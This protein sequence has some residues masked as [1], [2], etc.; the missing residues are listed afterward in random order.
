MLMGRLDVIACDPTVRRLLE[1]RAITNE[2]TTRQYLCAIDSFSRFKNMAP[3]RLVDHLKNL[4]IEEATEEVIDWIRYA[5]RRYSAKSTRNWLICL[6]LWLRENG[7]RVDHDEIKRAFR[8]YIGRV[9][10]LL[11]RDIITRDEL[12]KILQHCDIRSR[13]LFTFAASSGLRV[14]D[15]IIHLRLRDIKDDLWDKNL[16]CYLVE[17]PE[18]YTKDGVAHVTFISAECAQYLRTYL[19]QRENKGEN[20]TSDSLLFVARGRKPM[21][22]SL[23]TYLWA[24]ACKRAGVDRR[25]VKAKGFQYIRGAGLRPAVR[26][27]IRVHSLRKY[28][29]TACSTMGVDRMVSE[30]FLG[31]SLSAFGIESVYDFCIANLDYLRTQYQLVLPLVTFLVEPPSVKVVANHKARRE[32]EVLKAE[33]RRLEETVKILT[34]GLLAAHGLTQLSKMEKEKLKQLAEVQEALGSLQNRGDA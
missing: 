24:E 25:P 3:S 13:A 7:V 22:V 19:K 32:I 12:I 29:K 9:K 6:R 5:K 10:R 20:I 30:A 1:R 31:H 16:P 27:N 2:A 26:Y 15:T 23:V 21:S 11:V 17:V 34:M 18:S 14:R 33:V 8:S 4:S 28:F